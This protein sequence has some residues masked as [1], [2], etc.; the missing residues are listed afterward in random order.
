MKAMLL[1]DAMSMRKYLI[2]QSLIALFIGAFI[3][4]MTQTIYST[5][6][7]TGIM[8]VVSL[9]FSVIALDE[10][11]H[12]QEYRLALPL[13]RA[14]VVRGRYASL[15][16][17]TVLSVVLGVITSGLVLL[18]ANLLPSVEYLSP[19]QGSFDAQLYLLLVALTFLM[20]LGMLAIML[21]LCFKMGMTKAVRWIPL[22]GVL[23]FLLVFVGLG[24]NEAILP[25]MDAMA[26]T[27]ASPAGI[28]G[29]FV[30]AL[31]VYALSCCLSE[32]L[33]LTRQ[34]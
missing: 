3:D 5:P 21:P 11:G 19:I 9:S 29:V 12:W 30:A 25:S 6:I 27:M 28:V 31:A 22:V 26:H 33:Y 13:S 10:A 16:V 4:V 15:F 8:V 32:R 1:A 17:L 23:G 2:Q 18:A 7:F 34:F 24:S 20:C 14:N